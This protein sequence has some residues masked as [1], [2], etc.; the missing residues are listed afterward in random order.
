MPEKPYRPPSHSAPLATG[1]QP[2]PPGAPRPGDPWA[3]PAEGERWRLSSAKTMTRLSDGRSLGDLVGHVAGEVAG[4][5][6]QIRPSGGRVWID[7]N[8]DAVTTVEGRL[9]YLGRI[10]AAGRGGLVQP[11]AFGSGSGERGEA[12]ADDESVGDAVVRALTLAPGSSTREIVFW[13]HSNGHRDAS[14]S[15][16]N[17]LLYRES[18]LFERDDAAVPRW[19][20]SG[21][22]GS[23]SAS[24]AGAQPSTSTRQP[25]AARRAARL[26]PQRDAFADLLLDGPTELPVT[27][28]RATAAAR[29]Q[30]DAELPLFAWQREAIAAWYATGCEGIVEAVTGTGKTLVGLEAAAHAARDGQRSTVLVP[31]V[32]LQDQWADRFHDFL[33]HLTVARIGGKGEGDA[34]RADITIAVVNSAAKTDL[35]SLSPDSLLIADEVHRYGAPE[36]QL[37]LRSG[38]RRRLGL[39]ATLERS[40][41]GVD[42]VIRPYFGRTILTVG[43]DR[44]IRES[45]VAPFRLVMA[46]VSMTEDEAAEYETHGQKISNALKTLRAAGAL[47]ASGAGLVLQL[48]QLSGIPGKL[49][50]AARAATSGMR[51][52]RALLARL[53]GKLDAVEEL[54]EVI[55]ASQGSVL[56]TQSKE[57]AEAAALKLRSWGVA[58]SALHSDMDRNERLDTLA[59]LRD[60]R[61]QAVAAPKLL[62][63]GIDVPTVDLG[64]VMTA[65]RSRRQMVQRLGRVIRR[66]SD[67]RPVDFV[68]LYAAETV[69]D[70]DSGVHEGFFDL[71]GEVATNKVTLELGWTADDL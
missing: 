48:K 35:G 64:I 15:T 45:V 12:P 59:A 46:P 40:D 36:F 69:E 38:Y 65:S 7:G 33:P 54:S 11:R 24:S 58:A 60:G 67:G 53:E 47:N 5:F 32:D 13:L 39:T 19:R 52:R 55:A 21:T 20:L 34:K 44:A 3:G 57:T 10:P 8:G 61:L 1:L 26:T 29:T 28:S 6:L 70:P 43:F 23:P 31:S 62:D 2:S 4:Q 41:G 68:I 71:V 18:A 56:F 49:G 42:G 27:P 16:V 37:A 50:F 25:A 17:S 22:A 51:E 63:E 30:P 14:R 66:K 9:I